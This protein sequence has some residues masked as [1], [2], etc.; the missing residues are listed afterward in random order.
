MT[1]FSEGLNLL[2]RMRVCYENQLTKKEISWLLENCIKHKQ[3]SAYHH[4]QFSVLVARHQK[5][6]H[7][8]LSHC[9]TK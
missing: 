7:L 1:N 9:C 3:I 2:T 5:L 4:S 6:S 8:I